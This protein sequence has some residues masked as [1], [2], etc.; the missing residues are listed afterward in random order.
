M[1]LPVEERVEELLKKMTLEEKIGQLSQL[2]GN[3]PNLLDSV[4]K[5]HLGSVLNCDNAYAGQERQTRVRAEL[6]N[7]I[8]RVAVEE[9]R[10]GIPLL[11]GR[12]VIHGH[13]S[14]MPIP[15]GQAATWSPELVEAGAEV[16][17]REATADGLHWTFAPMLDIARDPRW[18]RVAEGFGEDPYLCAA[19]ARAS[20][21]GFQGE[22][23]SDPERMLACAKHFAGYGAA[24]GG[25][26]YNTMEISENTMRNVYLPSFEAA[27]KAGIGTLMSAFNENGG[28][29]T[30]ANRHL[31]TEILRDEWG[32][33]GFVVSDW[34][35]VEELIQHGAAG[36][37]MQAARMALTAGVDMEMCSKTYADRLADAVKQGL[38]SESTI[39]QAVRRV[40]RIKFRMGLFEKP[41]KDE[42]R[43]ATVMLCDAHVA[44]ARESAR[45]SIILLKND[46][47]LLPLPRTDI[48]LGLLGPLTDVKKELLGTWCCDGLPEDVV[49]VSE[50]VEAKMGTGGLLRKVAL[51]DDSVR[52]LRYCDKV[53]VVVGE[54]PRRSGEDACITTLDLPPG[55]LELLKGIHEFGLPMVVVVIAGRPLSLGWVMEHADAVLMVFHPG[56]QGG[57][58]IADVLFG[59]ENPSG[60]LPVTLPRCVGQVP[61]YYN[62]KLTGRPLPRN[63]LHI[64]RYQDCPDT[65]LLPFGYGLSYTTFSYA[66]L[67]ITPASAPV[68]G[69]VTV[70]AEVTNTGRRF[71]EEIVQCY[72]R[73]RV[74]STTRPVKELKGFARIGLQPGQTQRVSFVLGFDELSFFGPDNRRIVEPGEFTIWVGPNSNE[75]LQGQ[76]TLE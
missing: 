53:V 67:Q 55:Q 43:V 19:M 5:G 8:Q 34:E 51:Q 71:G 14:V 64:S 28:V 62:F 63:D 7:A 26:D 39:D 9:T 29:P 45:K 75:G 10:L 22:D 49:S 36:D 33:D 46:K 18:G 31:L 37:R 58:A 20:V 11:F 15:L 32:F 70:S 38:I 40:L 16:A 21:K 65:P 4:R 50:G 24:E 17:A 74:A 6:L 76:L 3:A 12:D 57:N 59:D 23:L 56:V 1:A 72:I 48:A 47:G 52:V 27:V 30:T 42:A 66:N 61:I 44:V 13:R 25:R 41:Y 35:A 2:A 54:S 68:G 73:D 69:T 60:K